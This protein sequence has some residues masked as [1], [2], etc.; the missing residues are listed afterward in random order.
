MNPRSHPGCWKW[1][2]RVLTAGLLLCGLGEVQADKKPTLD[3]REHYGETFSPVIIGEKA[4]RGWTTVEKLHACLLRH[5]DVEGDSTEVGEW[6][7]TVVESLPAPFR[8][9]AVKLGW[10][11]DFYLVEEGEEC[12]RVIAFLG[13]QYE[14][15]AFGI[16]ETFKISAVRRGRAAGRDY[17]W[18]ETFHD[19]GDSDPGINEY[20]SLEREEVRVVFLDGRPPRLRFPLRWSYKR[21]FMSG[22]PAGETRDLPIFR[23]VVLGAELSEDGILKIS[24]K[25]GHVNELPGLLGEH[26]VI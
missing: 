24:L 1:I 14:P 7:F 15:G 23:E 11:R 4:C 17:L 19:H 8:V 10:H 22:K 25:Q 2:L 20:K 21:D 9:L 16:H 5:E 12:V 13:G 18:I 26:R 3:L 6:E